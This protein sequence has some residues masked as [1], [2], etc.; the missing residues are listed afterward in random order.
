MVMLAPRIHSPCAVGAISTGAPASTPTRV[1]VADTGRRQAAGHS[2]GTLVDLEPGVPNRLVRLAGDHAL[3][4][5]VSVAEHVLG[6]P[7]HGGLLAS[8]ANAQRLMLLRLKHTLVQPHAH[9]WGAISSRIGD[10]TVTSGNIAV[11]E[12]TR[13][14]VGFVQRPPV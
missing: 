10:E 6:K 12:K 9:N 1:T 8:G 2:A 13:R 5:L 11:A 3:C 4:A 14:P 7:A